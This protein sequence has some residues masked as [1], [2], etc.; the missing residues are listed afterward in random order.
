MKI[1]VLTSL[2]ERLRMIITHLLKRFIDE[3]QAEL[4]YASNVVSMKR[5]LGA[6]ADVLV[7]Y[8]TG[9]EFILVE[10]ARK[11]VTLKICPVVF[12]Y[13]DAFPPDIDGATLLY[14][15][16]GAASDT[17]DFLF[18]ALQGIIRE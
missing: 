11:A 12:V 3:N 18:H 7:A 16:V 17:P 1:V 9:R 13:T 4:F 10:C 2:N 8:G 6:D 14:R 15:E 5:A